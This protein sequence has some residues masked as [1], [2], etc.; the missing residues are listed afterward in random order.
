MAEYWDRLEPTAASEELEP[1]LQARIA[2]PL[3][4]LGRQWQFGEFRGDDAA[5]PIQIR[6]QALSIP[7]TELTTAD[8]TTRRITE[9]RPL[10]CEVEGEAPGSG[11]GAFRHRADTG[12]RLVH[13]LRAD[14]VFVDDALRNT[15]PLR[16]DEADLEFL[17][18]ADR[19][20]LR[21]E[22]RRGIDGAALYRIANRPSRRLRLAGAEA[23]RFDRI[24]AQWRR[25]VAPLFA[26]SSDEDG[27]WVDER[28]EYDFSVRATGGDSEVT[29]H[30][31]E[32][33]GG[34]LDW[35]AFDIESAT[36]GNR[37]R[38]GETIDWTAMPT[39]VRY[40]G[41]PVPRWWEMEDG[42][43]NFGDVEG[44]PADLARA[45]VAGFASIFSDDWFLVGLRVP[46]GTL[47][48]IEEAVVHDTFGRTTPIQ[49]T[50]LEDALSGRNRPWRFFELS[51]DSF[52]ANHVNP[53]LFVPPVLAQQINGPAL[54]R[55][56]FVRDEAAN[57]GWAVEQIIESP[58]G[59]P[60]RRHQVWATS[61]PRPPDAA[62][63]DA[64]WRYRLATD[65]PPHWIPLLPERVGAS[66][67]IRLRRAR[68]EAWELLPDG[69]RGARGRIV[70]MRSALRIFEE[71]IPRGGL[72]ITRHWQLARTVDGGVV[73]WIGRRR[74]PGHGEKSAGL[75]WDRIE[76]TA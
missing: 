13:R 71:E 37:R 31:R 56:E 39:P 68:M 14:G 2:D 52:A 42:T 27:S 30:A 11:I 76:T 38:G 54:E 61:T 34:A 6:M 8:G 45:A 75:E 70:G 67:Q 10:E 69:L 1:G 26:R 73:T 44:G 3:W 64:T 20:R 12:A 49:S 63:T 17:P 25:D 41:M 53:W 24:H 60:I 18:P 51:G 7:L 35:Q 50:A 57:L 65:V 16:L 40:S 46:L 19:A 66:E 48:R 36:S 23:R 47:V 21:L 33:P 9:H 43:V 58:G 32:Y 59:R 5:T 72:E 55:V 15:F 22:A 74:R 28:L 29:L 62:E 4:L